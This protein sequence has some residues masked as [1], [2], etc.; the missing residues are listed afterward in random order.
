MSVL[1]YPTYS[2]RLSMERLGCGLEALEIMLAIPDYV[3]AGRP[4]AE[5]RGATPILPLY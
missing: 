3:L 1:H 2:N 4:K 5:R